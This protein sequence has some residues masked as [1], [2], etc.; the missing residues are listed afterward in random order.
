MR[1]LLFALSLAALSVSGSTPHHPAAPAAPRSVPQLD[2]LFG[3]LAKAGSDEEAKPI[4]DQILTLFLESGSA[5]VDLL[6]NRAATALAAGDM[7]TAQ[8]L[9]AVIT[10]VAPD[11]AEGWHQR[12]KLQ[13]LAGDDEGAIVSLQKAVTLNPRQFAAMTELGAILVEYGD[14]RDALKILRQAQSLDPHFSDI[15]REVRQL[16]R[17]VEGDRI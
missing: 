9:L 1:S 6:M 16:A 3:R 14:K 11:Y 8:Q 15:D 10:K 13:A 4:E 17:E 7:D 2:T 12:G 5:S